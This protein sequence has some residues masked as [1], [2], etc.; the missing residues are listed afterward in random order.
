[1]VGGLI[2]YVMVVL[3]VILG[4]VLV[5]ILGENGLVE[6]DLAFFYLVKIYLLVGVKGIIF[7]VFFVFFMSMVDFMFNFFVMLWLIDIYKI[8]IK[9]DVIDLEVVNVGWWVI[10]VIFFIGVLMGLVLFYVKFENL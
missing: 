2:K 4:I 5:G 6:F 10:F 8:Y 9:K 3:I 7:C 1:M